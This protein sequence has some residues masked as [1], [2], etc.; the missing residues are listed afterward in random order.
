MSSRRPHKNPHAEAEQFRKEVLA[1]LDLWEESVTSPDPMPRLN[2]ADATV[3]DELGE[4]KVERRLGKGATAVALQV[5]HHTE[6]LVLRVALGPEFN[7]RVRAEGQVLQK[8]HH[9]RIVGTARACELMLSGKMFDAADCERMGLVNRVVAPAD[10]IRTARELAEEMKKC[11]PL[12]LMLTRQ[13][14]YQ[15]Q[16]GTF[17]SQVRFE[18]YTL[19]YL[20]RTADHAEAVKAFREKRPPKFGGR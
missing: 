15:G 5:R 14:I 17:E 13:A 1:W 3:G 4:Y 20:Y 19:D 18:A 12:S 9:P 2:P 8:L 7:E 10:L 16:E 11:A 6:R